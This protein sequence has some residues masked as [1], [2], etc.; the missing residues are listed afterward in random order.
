MI[1]TFTS[2]FCADSRYS[3]SKRRKSLTVKN[4]GFSAIGLVLGLSQVLYFSLIFMLIRQGGR[5]WQL[6]VILDA[7][8]VNEARR[9]RC[10][11][12]CFPYRRFSSPLPFLSRYDFLFNLKTRSSVLMLQSCFG[13]LGKDR[14]VGCLTLPHFLVSAPSLGVLLVLV[15]DG[16]VGADHSF[17]LSG[18]YVDHAFP[19]WIGDQRFNDPAIHPPLPT[20]SHAQCKMSSSLANGWATLGANHFEKNSQELRSV[21]EFVQTLTSMRTFWLTW[22]MPTPLLSISQ[23]TFGLGLAAHCAHAN[24]LG[25]P[26]MS[27]QR[28]RREQL[29]FGLVEHISLL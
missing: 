4:H 8:W 10:H 19:E 21:D 28:S 9:L 14:W 1:V 15:V 12:R 16:S 18:E 29:S 13:I 11:F 5:P 17:L 26:Q 3:E 7:P 23:E 22:N 27:L 24:S 2:T 25:P 6:A 20:L